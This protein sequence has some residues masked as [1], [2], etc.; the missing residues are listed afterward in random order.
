LVVVIS[1]CD[2]RACA[3][4]ATTA[5]MLAAL[6]PN[7]GLV[8]R[9]PSPGGLR[10]EEVAEIAGLPLLVSMKSDP[11]LAEQLEHGG[12]RLGRRSALAA[13]GRPGPGGAAG[14]P[15]PPAQS[16]PA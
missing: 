9:G 10:A 13:G 3:A 6:N 1:P 14:G 2:V 7:I 5:P 4:P 11:R 15:A 16:R 8:V 12:L